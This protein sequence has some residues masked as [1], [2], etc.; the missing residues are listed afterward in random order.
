MKKIKLMLVEDHQIV[1]EGLK[2]LLDGH[3]DIEVA[4][5][6]HNGKHALEQL[7]SHLPDII[8]TDIT[9][10]I[11]DG[12]ELAAVIQNK[13]PH[14]KLL[15]LTMHMSDVYIKK[16]FAHG[17][18]GYLP[19]NIS[20]TELISA[21]RTISEG[22][23]Y[24]NHEVS[25]ILMNNMVDNLQN[26]QK[27]VARQST[28]LSERETEIVKLLAEGNNSQEIGEKLFISKKTVDNHRLNILQKLNV[29]NVAGLIK[30]AII[31]KLI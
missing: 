13:Y 8:L 15:V 26:E 28:D 14:V 24:F 12:F 18:S 30:Y 10:P 19:K 21:I 4:Y 22:K 9:M 5:E 23:K 6:A 11:L 1:R 25:A 17:A 2:E 3:H 16:A 20:K 7:K 31:N 29:K 27:S